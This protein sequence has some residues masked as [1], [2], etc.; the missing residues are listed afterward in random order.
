MALPFSILSSPNVEPRR[1]GKSADTLILHYTGMA[2]AEQALAW[3]CA[4]ESGVS[5]HYIVDEAGSVVNMVDEEM[6]AW[7]A[8]VSSWLGETDMNSRSIGIEV[9][10]PGH[11]GGYPDFPESQMAAVADL[12]RD[13]CARRRIAPERVLAHSDIAP[14]RKVDPGEK[15]DWGLLHRRGV[16]HWVPPVPLEPG[17]PLRR[18]HGGEDVQV[19]Q[20]L[21]NGYGYGVAVTGLFDGLTEACVTAFQRHFR[22]A[23]VDGVADASTVR[24]LQRLM[25]AL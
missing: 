3:L 20:A 13:I 1:D 18:G 4:A 12:C 9:H 22:Q 5:C 17:K 24:T 23:K 10:N 15:F 7:H 6:R 16:G 14:L 8:G 2:S 21:L 19:L 11:I 25:A